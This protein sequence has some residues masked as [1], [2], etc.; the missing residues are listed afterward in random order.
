MSSSEI[1][2]SVHQTVIFQLESANDTSTDDDEYFDV[3]DYTVAEV[4][5]HTDMIVTNNNGTPAPIW[6]R[7]LEGV[8]NISNVELDFDKD[9]IM[10]SDPD[11]KY[12]SLMAAYLSKA[13]PVTIELY[14]WI[15]VCKII[16]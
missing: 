5:A 14:I 16:Y 9:K 6:R 2:K 7:Y 4:Q 8:F 15:K 1:F 11:L 13:A 12:M 10:I 3:P